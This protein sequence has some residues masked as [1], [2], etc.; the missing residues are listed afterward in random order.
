MARK[1]EEERLPVGKL[2]AGDLFHP[3]LCWGTVLSVVEVSV[4]PVRDQQGLTGVVHAIR[5]EPVEGFWGLPVLQLDLDEPV[6]RLHPIAKSG[7][8]GTDYMAQLKEQ[9]NGA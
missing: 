3:P 7:I 5:V 4:I 2:E 1:Y 6:T 8:T 9:M